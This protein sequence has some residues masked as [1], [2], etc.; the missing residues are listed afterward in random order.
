MAGHAVVDCLSSPQSE[1][2]L[3]D[4]FILGTDKDILGYY[5]HRKFLLRLEYLRNLKGNYLNMTIHFSVLHFSLYLL[6]S[7]F[8]NIL[9]CPVVL[10]TTKE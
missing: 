8:V 1:V 6:Y 4:I 2:R 7:P 9:L 5:L 10:G 3:K